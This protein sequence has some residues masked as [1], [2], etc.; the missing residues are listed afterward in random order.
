MKNISTILLYSTID[1]CWLNECLSSA[2]VVSDEV[3]VTT[4]EK[5]WN[6]D[7]EN[8]QLMRESA[9][10]INSYS[11]TKHLTIPWKP[12]YRSFFFEA[13]CRTAGIMASDLDT[14]YILFLDTDE[15]IDIDKFNDWIATKEYQNYDSMKLANYWYF[16]DKKYRAK[17]IEDSVV[18]IKKNLVSQHGK[19]IVPT[20]DTGR[21]QY[22]EL[23]N[24]NKKRMIVGIDGTPMIHH[25]SWVRNKQEMITKVKCWGHNTDRDWMSLIEE[26]FSRP[27]NGKCFVNNYSFDIL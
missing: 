22:H 16:R 18:L 12:G 27:F 8:Q 6:G 26:E 2:S 15:I 20:I 24:C 7:P 19:M 21:E 4:C 10:I 25:Y 3:I 1:Y 13:Q 23:I 17:T 9:D 5:L 11:N 14:D